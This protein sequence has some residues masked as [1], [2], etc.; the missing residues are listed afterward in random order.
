MS[1]EASPWHLRDRQ[2]GRHAK[3]FELSSFPGTRGGA[4]ATGFPLEIKTTS[5]IPG[6][7]NIYL[8]LSGADASLG[9]EGYSLTITK[10]LVTI[11]ANKPEGLFSIK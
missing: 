6:K 7:G 3:G 10:K 2:S 4:A 11:A 9:D 5:E 1:A 8:T